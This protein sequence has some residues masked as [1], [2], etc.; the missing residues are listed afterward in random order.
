MESLQDIVKKKQLQQGKKN[1]TQEFQDLGLRIAE[2]LNDMK[3]KALYIKM[4]KEKDRKILVHA[5]RYVLDYPN[6]QK[7]AKIFMWKVKQLEEEL[8]KEKENPLEKSLA[9]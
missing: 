6:P 1:V 8:K 7:P 4:A 5:L 2:R 3:H 9:D